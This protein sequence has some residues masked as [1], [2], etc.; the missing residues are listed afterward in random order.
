MPRPAPSAAPGM[1]PGMSAMTKLAS[2]AG[3]HH[4]EVRDE[5]REGVV[6]HLGPRA[7]DG[8][9]EGALAD[10]GE[11]EQAHVGEHLE[12]EAEL[13]LLARLARARRGAARGRRAWRSG[14][15]R[16]RP[17]RRARRRRACPA[18]STSKTS[19]PVSTSKPCVPDG[20]ARRRGPRRPSRTG[21][22]RARARRA[23]PRA[24]A[25]GRR[26]AAS[27][28]PRRRRRRRRRPCRRRRR[29]GR[30]KARTSRGGRR[31]TRCR[32]RPATTFTSHESTN[33]TAR[34]SGSLDAVVPGAGGRGGDGARVLG[35]CDFGLALRLD[36]MHVPVG[37]GSRREIWMRSSARPA[38]VAPFPRGSSASF[39]SMK[40]WRSCSHSGQRR[41][42]LAL[43]GDRGGTPS[44]E[45][46]RGRARAS[47]D[48]YHA[49]PP[50]LRTSMSDA[51]G[52][53]AK[54]VR[55]PAALLGLQE[56]VDAADRLR[57][58]GLKPLG[59]LGALPVAA[60]TLAA[61]RVSA[62]TAS[63]SDA[64]ARRSSTAACAR[65]VLRSSRMTARSATCSSSSSSFH[66]RKRKDAGRRSPRR[67]RR[68]HRGHRRR[69]SAPAPL[70]RSTATVVGPQPALSPHDAPPV[71]RMPPCERMHCLLT[72]QP[73]RN[74]SRRVFSRG[75]PRAPSSVA[76]AAP[77][78][79]A[80]GL[81]RA[82][83]LARPSRSDLDAA[84]RRKQDER[85]RD[86]QQDR[87]QELD[88]EGPTRCAASCA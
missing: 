7:R 71:A 54:Q 65:S 45:G 64:T 5:R 88:R 26:R 62:A 49:R 85:A 16:G 46:A 78:V 69:A 56:R 12:L 44:R 42:R 30:R 28:C 18:A 50:P 31:R 37:R 75:I 55:E 74:R 33:F 58:G 4:A 82:L 67:S 77:S 9:D 68:P 40:C 48:E 52:A 3:L 70:P 24:C 35:L 25:G 34:A 8:A 20:H 39:R 73:G 84:A 21:P 6:G 81:L 63:A 57:D 29:R 32:R 13:L 17:G 60:L 66:A 86:A 79:N 41:H 19:S 1:R 14:C 43:A 27:S 36:L 2:S 72:F 51:Q 80:R 87:A 83:F 10:V 76:T 38:S 22:C 53:R 61:S 11:A 15:C 47:R 23:R 59:A